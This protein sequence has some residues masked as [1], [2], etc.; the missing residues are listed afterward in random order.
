MN[1]L[2]LAFAC[3]PKRGSEEGVGWNWSINLA[4]HHNVYV[5]TRGQEKP[6][7]DKYIKET[8][9]ENPKFYYFEDEGLMHFVD[10][11]IPMGFRCYYRWWQGQIVEMAKVIIK[12]H[13]IDIIHQLTYNEYRTPGKLYNMGIPFVWGPIGGGHEYNAILKNGYFRKMDVFKE[14]VRKMLNHRY[15]KNKDVVRAIEISAEILVAD[16][17]TY[18]ILPKTREYRKLLEAAYYPD[19]NDIKIYENRDYKKIRLMYAGVMIPRKGLKIIIDALGESSFRD[20][21]LILIGDGIDKPLLEKL[22]RQYGIEDN[23][24][25]LGKL[26][27]DEVNNYYDWADLFLFPSMRDTSGNVVLEAMSH[28]T[29]VIALN[30]NGVSEMI[31]SESG[32]LIEIESYEQIKKD[33]VTTIKK[34]QLDRSLLETKGHAARERL[35]Q[36]Y[37]WSHVMDVIDSVYQKIKDNQGVEAE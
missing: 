33:Y 34:Y 28:G 14:V 1:I 20:F 2:V 35:E 23:V 26:S 22:V 5:I 24:K 8:R 17:A 37:S 12:Q 11:K 21:E 13:N 4:K 32:D 30:H 15:L 19:R 29:P 36:V 25:F 18:S 16:P 9:I 7:I 31:T 6:Y 3:E 10:K 27:Y